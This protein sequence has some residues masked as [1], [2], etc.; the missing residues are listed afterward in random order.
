MPEQ[1]KV[2]DI[3]TTA[4][5]SLF[6]EDNLRRVADDLERFRFHHLPVVD[7]GKLPMGR[8]DLIL[9]PP[10][11][12]HEHGHEGR[13]V[14]GIRGDVVDRRCTPCLTHHEAVVARNRQAREQCQD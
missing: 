13:G 2:S 11:L 3:M 1:T 6:E 5:V 12:W 4:V 9:T 7:G 14:V 10:G 8:G